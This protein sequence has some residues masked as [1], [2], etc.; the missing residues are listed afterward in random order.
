M[1]LLQNEKN[2]IK[3][4]GNG[5]VEGIWEMLLHKSGIPRLQALF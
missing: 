5:N 2:K 4:K 3:I 1:K